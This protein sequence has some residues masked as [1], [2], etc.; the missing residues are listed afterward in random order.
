[1]CLQQ[2]VC[3]AVGVVMTFLSVSVLIDLK[4]RARG[5]V[6][7]CFRAACAECMRLPRVQ[8]ATPRQWTDINCDY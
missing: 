4:V 5:K 8:S 6:L 3:T 7:F 1:L 2:F